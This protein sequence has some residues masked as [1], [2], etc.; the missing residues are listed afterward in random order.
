LCLQQDHR[1]KA[2]TKMLT[3]NVFQP[4]LIFLN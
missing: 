2:V 3:K 4:F 1:T